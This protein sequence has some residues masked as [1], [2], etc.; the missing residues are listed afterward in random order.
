VPTACANASANIQIAS[1]PRQPA[2]RQG[3]GPPE[4]RIGRAQAV[5][6]GRQVAGLGGRESRRLQDRIAV[7]MQAVQAQRRMVPQHVA[8]RGQLTVVHAGRR[9]CHV[10]KAGYLELAEVAVLQVDMAGLERCRVRPVA[11][12]RQQVVGAGLQRATRSASPGDTRKN[13]S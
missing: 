9:L 2:P 13:R 3:A 8:Q 11:Q 12:R 7:R 4:R 10:A 5:Q 6:E 1:N